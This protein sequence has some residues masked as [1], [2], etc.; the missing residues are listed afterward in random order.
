MKK[1]KLENFCKIYY[2]K[3]GKRKVLCYEIFDV[4]LFKMYFNECNNKPSI[5][6]EKLNIHYQSLR[7]LLQDADLWKYVIT[8]NGKGSGINRRRFKTSTRNG[9]L[10]SENPNSVT[11]SNN[12]CRRKM[13][14]IE[15]ME[16]YLGRNLIK[17]EIIHHIDCNKLNNN[18][19]N[20]H[21]C[22]RSEHGNLHKN[23]EKQAALL[24]NRGLIKF[25]PQ[26][27]Y[28]IDNLILSMISSN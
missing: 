3:T 25:H 4:N 19:E 16:N 24:I 20:L 11:Y 26:N 15:V 21:L 13:K 9:Y 14:H 8:K 22:S 12:R 17:G 6:A 23:L 27:G 10:Y 5:L 2:S 7:K 28:Y 18:I 1:M